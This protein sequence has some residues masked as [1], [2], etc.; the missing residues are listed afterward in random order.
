MNILYESFCGHVS[1]FLL[2]IYIYL[3]GEWLGHRMVSVFLT[4]LETMR[5]F[6]KILE[7]FKRSALQEDCVFQLFQH[8]VTLELWV[9]CLFLIFKNTILWSK[10]SDIVVLIANSLVSNS[11]KQFLHK[12]M[13]H[14]NILFLNCLLLLSVG[15]VSFSYWFIGMLYISWIWVLRIFSP[16]V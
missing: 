1:F 3:S 7:L 14:L 4:L 13:V 6:S 8:L 11:V 10:H 5:K 16:S 15:M 2:E 9:L 12:S